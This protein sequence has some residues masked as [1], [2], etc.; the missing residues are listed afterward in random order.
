MT[1]PLLLDEMFSDDVA[2]RLR[3]RHH[4]VLAVVADPDL[5]GLPDSQ[6]LTE[7]AAG[8]RPW[9]PPTSRTSCRSTP[10]T[11]RSAASTPG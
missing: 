1:Y 7:A 8:G 4:D 3:K 10:S 2:G 5:V 6:I 11:R 9:S